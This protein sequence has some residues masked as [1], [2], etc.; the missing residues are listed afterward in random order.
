MIV[1]PTII[2]GIA[3]RKDKSVKIVISTQEIDPKTAAHIFS[4]SGNYAYVAI[5]QEQFTQWEVDDIAK[6]KADIENIKSPSQRLRAIL[7]RNFEQNNMGYNDF[8]SYYIAQMD[9]I[10]EHY[11]SKLLDF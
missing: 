7:Y 9:K 11:K 1:I 4:L 5:K 3:T 8:T 10:C 2:E 6:L